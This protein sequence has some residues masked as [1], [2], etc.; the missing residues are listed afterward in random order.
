M[1]IRFE[2]RIEAAIEDIQKRSNLPRWKIILALEGDERFK[3]EIPEE[4]WQGAVLEVERDH[5]EPIE[6]SMLK[7]RFG[8]AGTIANRVQ[9][10][11]HRHPTF[12]EKLGDATVKPFIGLPIAAIILIG[13]FKFFITTA[14]FITDK[15]MVPFFEGPYDV[16]IR[17]LIEGV[18][19]EGFIHDILIGTPGAGYLESFGVLTTGI[20]VPIGIVLP[21]VLI[22][23][24]ILT[25]LEDV[26]YLPRLAILVDTIFH[27]IGLHGYSIVPVILSFGCNVPGV[28]ATRV[29]TSDKQRFMMLTLLGISIPCM[30]QTAV[31]LRVIGPFG[32]RWV[33]LI[34]LV[35][36]AIFV[37]MGSIL[38]RVLKGV[39]PEIAI[40]IPP[41]RLPRISNLVMKTGLRIQQ[42]L[43]EAIPWVFVGIILVN[44]LHTL[45]ITDYLS[46]ILGPLLGRWLGLPEEAIYPLII[47]FLRKDVA[48]GLLIPLLNENIMNFY[49][50]VIAVTILV[51]YFPCAATFAVFLKELGIRGTI[52]STLIMLAVAFGVGGLL[53]LILFSLFAL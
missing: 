28:M 44:I 41:Y 15:I 13:V 33:I 3:K 31:I 46:Q 52:K 37:G 8:Q 1:E 26:G 24:I 40:E 19:P 49:Q 42:F 5:K 21:A 30:A 43:L 53:H 18:F 10:V 25:L 50:A 14:G 45:R 35:L 17:S 38:H 6:L 22:F 4:I 39:A 47:G 9:K 36:M 12:L 51:I 48:T 29:L 32:L 34:Y 20:F 7:A 27:R 23:Y 2:P 11:R 16:F